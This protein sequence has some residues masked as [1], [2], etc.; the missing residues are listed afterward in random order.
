MPTASAAFA[1]VE[2]SAAVAPLQ[3]LDAYALVASAALQL[4]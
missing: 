2:P 3:P 1:S 4:G